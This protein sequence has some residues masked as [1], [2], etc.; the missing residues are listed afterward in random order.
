MTTSE[1][2]R[3]QGGPG[4]S[5]FW[6]I[7]G[8]VASVL[9]ALSLIVFLSSII[10]LG[11]HGIVREAIDWWVESVRPLGAPA[12]DQYEKYS[13]QALSDF[14]RDYFLLG[15]IT[16]ISYARSIRGEKSM[17]A[18]GIIIFCI[19]LALNFYAWPL[20]ILKTQL[21][22]LRDHPTPSALVQVAIVFSP[23][24]YFGLILA[25]NTWLL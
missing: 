9:G 20:V 13:G 5:L 7:Y 14:W 23:V 2:A 15:V 1:E 24:I 3:E 4:F 22:R 17:S 10:D 16:T 18:V 11:P 25:A 19:E 8:Q 6:G 12:F 21:E